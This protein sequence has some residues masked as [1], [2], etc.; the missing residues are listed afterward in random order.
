MLKRKVRK[1]KENKTYAQITT[2][3]EI[4]R[5][6]TLIH[7]TLDLFNVIY[8]LVFFVHHTSSLHVWA[9]LVRN[10]FDLPYVS[11]YEGF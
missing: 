6:N 10:L 2:H 1:K 3:S 7:I 8:I 11:D 5:N 4:K 9:F